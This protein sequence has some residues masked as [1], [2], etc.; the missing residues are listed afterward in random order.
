MLKIYPQLAEHKEEIVPLPFNNDE[1]EVKSVVSLINE[2]PGD[3]NN[4][5]RMPRKYKA[6]YIN[7]RLKISKPESWNNMD[8]KLQEAYITLTNTSGEFRT[9]FP[10]FELLRA[11]KQSNSIK[12]L[13]SE[14]IRKG[15][16]NGVKELTHNLMHDLRVKKERVGIVNE[17]I[18]LLITQDKTYGLYDN[19]EIGWLTRNGDEYSPVQA[20]PRALR[21]RKPHLWR[22]KG[23]LRSA[24]VQQFAHPALQSPRVPL[25][26]WREARR[27]TRSSCRKS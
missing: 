2:R 7:D 6:Q 27:S 11:M 1:L 5:A 15:I 9:R 13:N 21:R 25:P 8:K 23:R 24:P 18:E 16:T 19:N 12:L 14:M 22:S 26:V 17:N 3:R 10:N 20:G 4:F